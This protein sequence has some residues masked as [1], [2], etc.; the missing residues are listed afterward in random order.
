MDMPGARILVVED[1]EMLREL[2]LRNLERRGHDVRAAEDAHTALAYLRTAPF[3]LILLDICLP[4]ETG[5]EVLRTAQKE[6]KLSP[7]ELNGNAGRLPVVVLSA[8]R[9]SP[10]RLQEFHPLAYLPKPFPM[11]AVLRLASEA[12]GRRNGDVVSEQEEAY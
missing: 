1:D 10:G 5:W 2:I 6:G 7:L 12:A 9:V 4:D 8:V 3:D 11:E